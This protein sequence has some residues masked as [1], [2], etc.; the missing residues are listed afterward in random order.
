MLPPPSLIGNLHFIF[1]RTNFPA[2][3]LG[4]VKKGGCVHIYMCMYISFEN[5]RF[6]TLCMAWK[7]GA[8]SVVAGLGPE[9]GAPWW[10]KRIGVPRS[11]PRASTHTTP[12][13]RARFWQI[14][15]LK[16][17]HW[18]PLF[19]GREGGNEFESTLLA[20][21]AFVKMTWVDVPFRHRFSA[22]D[23]WS[24]FFCS[25]SVR[26][27]NRGGQLHELIGTHGRL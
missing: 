4:T 21:S 26:E 12:K 22:L 23:F 20:V 24:I 14:L 11:T 2:F 8:V 5:T 18:Q 13:P 16:F 27:S 3:C 25:Y 15:D 17:Q 1:L 10:A 19:F 6:V 7:T 9:S